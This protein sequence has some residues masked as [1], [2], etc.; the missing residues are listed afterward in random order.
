MSSRSDTEDIST[1]Q[2]LPKRGKDKESKK[3]KEK[4]A[5]LSKSYG[6]FQISV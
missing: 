3:K 4:T 1:N 5:C 2:T 6:N